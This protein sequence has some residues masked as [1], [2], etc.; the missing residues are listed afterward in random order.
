MPIPVS[1]RAAPS[2]SQ[3][4]CSALPLYICV[5]VCVYLSSTWVRRFEFQVSEA[6]KKKRQIHLAVKL[7]L[8][9]PSAVHFYG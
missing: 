4:F 7:M 3:H 8:E 1:G 6:Y 2:V 5:C 9:F